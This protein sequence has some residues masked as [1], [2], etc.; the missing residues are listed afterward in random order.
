M[1]K[2]HPVRMCIVCRN[3]Y[4]QKTLIRLKQI[5]KEIVAFDGMG[6]SFYLCKPCLD[7]PKKVEGL[8]KRFGQEREKLNSLLRVLG[9]EIDL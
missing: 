5:D 7:N 4:P 2:R 1:K 3:R 8:C 6:R 9:A